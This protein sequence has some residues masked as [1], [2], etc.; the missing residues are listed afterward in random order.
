MQLGPY[1]IALIGVGATIIGALVGAWVGYRLSLS[2]SQITAKQNAALHLKEAFKSELLALAPSQHA[3]SE[4]IPNF[5][6]RSF[7]K[8]REAIFDFSFYLKSDEKQNFYQAWYTYYCPEEN[9]SETSVPFLEQ[10]SCRGFNPAQKHE[11]MKK[12]RDRIWRVLE[13]T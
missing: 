1:E 6:E 5:L 7:Q 9:R 11:M 8:H 10:Y 12:V 4:D 13:F 3:L 2:L